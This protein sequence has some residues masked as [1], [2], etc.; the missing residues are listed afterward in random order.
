MEEIVMKKVSNEYVFIVIILIFWIGGISTK[1]KIFRNN[2]YTEHICTLSRSE[3]LK[4]KFNN[5]NRLKK[6]S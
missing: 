3:R 6:I 4:K 5:I 1:T 2:L